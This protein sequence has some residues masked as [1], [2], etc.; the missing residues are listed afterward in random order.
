MFLEILV[1][2]VGGG[3]GTIIGWLLVGLLYVKFQGVTY[4]KALKKNLYL[5][6]IG[7]IVGATLGIIANIFN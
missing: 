3:I 6:P 2:F 4:K 1:S 7:L 5:I